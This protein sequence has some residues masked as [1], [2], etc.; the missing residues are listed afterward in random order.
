MDSWIVPASSLK[1][2]EVFRIGLVDCAGVEPKN[3]EVFRI[4]LVDRPRVEPK[5]QG[6]VPDWTRGSSPRSFRVAPHRA[7]RTGRCSKSDPNVLFSFWTQC[8]YPHTYP[9]SRFFCLI[10]SLN[11]NVMI[12]KVSS[13]VLTMEIAIPVSI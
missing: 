4:G 12:F 2:E 10:S 11:I 8:Y 7:L 5:K 9:Y 13:P 1:K 6:G 3:K